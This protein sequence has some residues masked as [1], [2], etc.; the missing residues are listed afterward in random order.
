[1]KSYIS[2]RLK[3]IS[4]VP[5]RDVGDRARVLSG[6]GVNVLHLLGWP[7]LVPPEHIAK[8]A[9]ESAASI[10][11]PD[12]SGIPELKEALAAKVHEENS[13]QLHSPEE[14]IIITNGAFHAIYIVLLTLLEPGDEVL[15][16]APSFFFNGII[17]FTS[18][19]TRYVRLD[20]NLGF[21]FDPEALRAAVSKRTKVLMVNTPANPT[22]YVATLEELKAILE[23][24]EEC[25]LLVISDESYE[26][27]VYDGLR[28]YSIGALQGAENRVVT[29]QSFTKAYAMPQWR[30]GYIV[31]PA[32]FYHYFV[33]TLEWMVLTC[34]YVAQRCAWAAVTG[35]GEWWKGVARDF[36]RKRDLVYSGMSAIDG[37]QCIKPSGTPF[38]FPRVRDLGLSGT[39]FA[40]YVLEDY[41]ITAVPGAAFQ[42]DDHVRIPFGAGDD[43]LR[44]LVGRM[45]EAVENLEKKKQAMEH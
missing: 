18:G 6:K 17:E 13:I 29:V 8:V 28:H 4:R 10:E 15:L 43:V 42:D 20:R 38:V 27:M 33:K 25:D 37:V 45:H 5:S 16:F 35:P 32:Q 19:V 34:N 40:R 30:V 7:T 44:D 36:Q 39:E 21:C 3:A 9:M 26:R 24:A 31:C 23:V 1:M 2:D 41:G 22:G 11:H 12:S 14:Q